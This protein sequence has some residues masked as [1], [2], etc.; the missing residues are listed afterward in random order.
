VQHASPVMR[1]YSN[2]QCR[3]IIPDAWI[4]RVL[5]AIFSAAPGRRRPMPRPQ[6]AV[7]TRSRLTMPAVRCASHATRFYRM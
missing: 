2:R 6:T 5:H 4:L 7:P 3:R 1:V